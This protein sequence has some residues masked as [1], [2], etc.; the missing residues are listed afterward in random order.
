MEKI[1]YEGF[2]FIQPDYDN[3]QINRIK[4]AKAILNGILIKKPCMI[5]GD[6]M[7]QMA[8]V[9]RKRDNHEYLFKGHRNFGFDGQILSKIMKYDKSHILYILHSLFLL[10]G[11]T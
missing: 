3:R 5:C 9:W 4:T 1:I 8:V 6:K 11:Y 7:S 10:H 2:E